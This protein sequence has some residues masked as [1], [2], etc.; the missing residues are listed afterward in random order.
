MA[1]S[2]GGSGGSGMR[3]RRFRGAG[4]STLSEMN[5]VPLVDVVLVLL[6]IFMLT[7]QAMEFGLDIQVPQVKQV[8]KSVEDLPVISLTRDGKL[9]LGDQ[10][11]SNINLMGAE[12]GKRYK[13][14][15]AVYVRTDGRVV[16]ENLLQVISALSEAHYEV[17]IVTKPM[18]SKP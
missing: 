2:I 17:K 15:K 1:F 11:V 8:E 9:Y 10:P 6:I 3:G 5:V 14:T 12:V 13:G 18:T 7:A 4:G 16:V